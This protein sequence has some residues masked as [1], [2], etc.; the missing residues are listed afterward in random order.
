MPVT[1]AYDQ[2][3]EFV[4]IGA[5]DFEVSAPTTYTVGQAT[6]DALPPAVMPEPGILSLS[7]LGGV[8]FA[9]RYWLARK[10]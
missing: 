8:V 9:W 3:Y 4:S 1:L 6:F 5:F 10:K 2:P 7:A